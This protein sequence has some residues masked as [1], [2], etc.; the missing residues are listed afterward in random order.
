M[1]KKLRVAIV[2]SGISGLVCAYF[3]NK[4]YEIKFYEKNDYIGGH[5]N[6]VDVNYEG[7]KIAVDTGFIVF[8]H[9]TYPN[10]K[11]FFELLNVDYEPSKMSFAV[12][13]GD[14]KI[15]YAGTN[16]NA[17]FAQRKNILNPRFIKMLLDILRFNKL[18]QTLLNQEFN[19]DYSMMNFLQDLK[20][21]KFFCDY[22]LLPMASAIWSTPLD[23][24]HDYPASSFVRFFKNHGLLTVSDQPQ[25]LTVSKG[26]R[27]YVKKVCTDFNDK[28]S[29]NDEVKNIYQNSDKKWVIESH[30]STEIFD[31]IVIASHADQALKILKNPTKQQQEILSSF[32]YQKNLAVLHKDSAVMPK[33]KK[34]WAS[35]VYSHN[36]SA[37]NLAK[38]NLSVSYWM[39]NLQNIDEA[40]PLFVTLN[41][42]IEIDAKNIF[43]KF[44]YE[45]PIFDA[46]AVK[47]QA[48]IDEIQGQDDIYFCGAYQSFG[49]HED[50]I[51]S[52]LRVLNKMQ[53]KAS[54]Q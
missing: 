44:E 2:G 41:P 9:Q 14:S 31:K 52:A 35:W 21:G 50:G 18:A 15:E 33:A 12:K 26:S 4:N 46:K 43:A 13:I 48:R 16:L 1:D 30:K 28:I 27:Q 19:P 25:W 54:W 6:T 10:L 37:K 32:S 47:A 17:V 34:A 8:N 38:N 22:Y 23:K 42:N 7:K 5:S 3:L 36:S 53:I 39:N 11:A 51:S 40:Y 20:V 45:H 24:I 49:F 29:L